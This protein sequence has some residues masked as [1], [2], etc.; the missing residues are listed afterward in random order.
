LVDPT[1][2]DY[3]LRRFLRIKRAATEPIANNTRLDGSGTAVTAPKPPTDPECNGGN[4]P[5]K[6]LLKAFFQKKKSANAVA[7]SL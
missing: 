7:G 1:L 5:A 4:R 3:L 6:V 2:G